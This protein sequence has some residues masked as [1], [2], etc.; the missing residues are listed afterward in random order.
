VKTYVVKGTYNDKKWFVVDASNMVL[1][2]MASRVAH[3][4]RGKHKPIYSPH[5]DLG[6]HIIIVNAE[7]VRLTGTKARF[8]KYYRYSGYPSGL[9]EES[10]LKVIKEKPEKVIIHAVKGMLP[11]NRLGRKLIKK[12]RV[13]RGPNHPHSAQQPESLQLI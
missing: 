11:H 6:D 4:L 2:R 10:Y 1:G 3:I 9:K 5:I 7:R 8:K 13:Y 12:L